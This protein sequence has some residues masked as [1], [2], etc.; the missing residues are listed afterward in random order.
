MDFL[1]VFEGHPSP[2]GLLDYP[3]RFL[4]DLAGVRG[5]QS[6]LGGQN[7]QKIHDFRFDPLIPTGVLPQNQ[8]VF[9]CADS[10]IWSPKGFVGGY[11]ML[12]GFPVLV[13][14]YG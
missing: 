13:Y 3:D 14:V 1:I 5:H 9:V 2:K 6:G 8:R 11:F 4:T 7:Y 10:D 12:A